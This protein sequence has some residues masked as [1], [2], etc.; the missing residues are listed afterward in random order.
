MA[1]LLNPS[2][3]LG[4]N[5]QPSII[6]YKYN[7]DFKNFASYGKPDCKAIK[8]DFNDSN[9]PIRLPFET[10]SEA[11][12]PPVLL[13]RTL[14]ASMAPLVAVTVSVRRSLIRDANRAKEMLRFWSMDHRIFSTLRRASSSRRCSVDLSIGSASV[15]QAFNTQ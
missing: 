2:R 5:P 13:R 8:S 7:L 4:K 10:T 3:T 12:L 11:T 6:V 1:Q 9:D 15:F 14:A